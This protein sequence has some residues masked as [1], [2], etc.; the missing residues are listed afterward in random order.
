MQPIAIDNVKV[1]NLGLQSTVLH[2]WMSFSRFQE[3][4]GTQCAF[5]AESTERAYNGRVAGEWGSGLT[6]LA[7]ESFIDVVEYQLVPMYPVIHPMDVVALLILFLVGILRMTL[8][9]VI[10]AIMISRVRDC[11]WWL[12]GT[13]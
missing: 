10:R 9:I 8:N 5:I 6:D 13:F 4:Q 7:T 1:M 12:M 3:S 2:R 11:G